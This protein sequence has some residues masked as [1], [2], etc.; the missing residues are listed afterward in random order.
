MSSLCV[1]AY[2]SH[3]HCIIVCRGTLCLK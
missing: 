3:L 1:F 2:L